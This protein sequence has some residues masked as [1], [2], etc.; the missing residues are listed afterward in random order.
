MNRH[1]ARYGPLPG[2]AFRQHFS[3]RGP[4]TG[5]AFLWTRATRLQGLQGLCCLKSR[6]PVHARPRDL[7]QTPCTCPALVP[8]DWRRDHWPKP[9]SSEPRTTDLSPTSR[10]SHSLDVA[11]IHPSRSRTE[12][13]F[14]ASLT[15][16][17]SGSSGGASS[18]WNYPPGR[19]SPL[20]RDGPVTIAARP[21]RQFPIQ[22]CRRIIQ[23]VVKSVI[24]PNI[25][26]SPETN[27]IL[28]PCAESDAMPCHARKTNIALCRAMLMETLIC[29]RKGCLR[30]SP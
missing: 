30:P 13:L 20:L 4:R 26:L 15:V 10:T 18:T 6:V 7:Q 11:R 3:Y 16:E 27:S 21:N 5:G 25:R 8:G 28:M 14:R 24:V 29:R 22:R 1:G 12:T 23:S 19:S 9:P 2:R 17:T